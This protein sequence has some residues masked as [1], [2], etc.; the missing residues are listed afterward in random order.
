MFVCSCGKKYSTELSISKY[1]ELTKEDQKKLL[2]V[3]IDQVYGVNFTDSINSI[4]I[5]EN[6]STLIIH[7]TIKLDNKLFYL[8]EGDMLINPNE[9][10]RELFSRQKLEFASINI[11]N[12][13]CLTGERIGDTIIKWKNMP[14]KY[15]V[16]YN[17]FENPQDYVKIVN[18]MSQAT[19]DWEKTCGVK[20]EY[21]SQFDNA[22]QSYQT[23]PQ[24][25]FTIIE[26]T[27]NY[28]Y[29]V[30]FTP[31]SPLEDRKLR[32]D[33]SFYRA[34]YNKIGILRH[35]IGHI[36]GFKHEHMDKS[37]PKVCKSRFAEIMPDT[38]QINEYDSLSV[39][40]YFCGGKGSEMLKITDT[41]TKGAQVFYGPPF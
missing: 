33:K 3:D 7:D 35:E 18:L 13:S 4:N 29:A 11:G 26:S 22:L 8:A 15:S 40:H 23:S 41:D 16:V 28:F 25:D 6:D 19:S 38:F 24:I 36:L 14:I 30:A 9:F 31:T 32:I 21:L 20:F 10:G 5:F 34:P 37:A 2:I 39:M 17:S 1:S 27:G 12:V